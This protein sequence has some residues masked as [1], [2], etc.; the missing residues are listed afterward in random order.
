[1]DKTIRYTEKPLFESTQQMENK[2]EPDNS[3]FLQ[4]LEVEYGK[5]FRGDG[6]AVEKY[7]PNTEK[8]M[9]S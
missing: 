6:F 4:K 7:N 8:E 1:M 9:N 3:N 2:Q 5:D